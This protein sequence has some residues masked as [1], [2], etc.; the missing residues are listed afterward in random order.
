M[1][2]WVVRLLLRQTRDDLAEARGKGASD[3]SARGLR[4]AEWASSETNAVRHCVDDSGKY[5][6]RPAGPRGARCG[7]ALHVDRVRLLSLQLRRNRQNSRH[8]RYH[9]R[10]HPDADQVQCGGTAV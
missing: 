9:P 1:L 2:R 3:L 5:S 4:S 8:T 7:M 10:A 6:A